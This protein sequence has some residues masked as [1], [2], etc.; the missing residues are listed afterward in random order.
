MDLVPSVSL[1]AS[2]VYTTNIKHSNGRVIN[3]HLDKNKLKTVVFPNPKNAVVYSLGSLNGTVLNEQN[4]EIELPLD[5]PIPFVTTNN[6][7]VLEVP[8]M[9]SLLVPSVEES[10]NINILQ[11]LLS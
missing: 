9:F 3:V 7:T 11:K 2:G 4:V 1:Y 8:A 5:L 6:N 10:L